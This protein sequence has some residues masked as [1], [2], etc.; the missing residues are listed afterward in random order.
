M[1]QAIWLAALAV[2]N[3]WA[4]GNLGSLGVPTN[5]EK[6]MLGG[7]A[8]GT[9]A[10]ALIGRGNPKAMEAGLTLPPPHYLRHP[11]QYF[12][13]SPVTTPIPMQPW[14]AD[15]VGERTIAANDART[16]IRP[17]IPLGQRVLCD[18]P[19]THQEILRAMPR[20]N[21]GVPFVYEEFRD[22][23]E[24]ATE[25]L[26]DKID[27]PRFYPLIGPAQMHHCHW[28]CTVY[29]TETV[30]V[31]YPFPMKTKR[32]RME[33]VYIDKDHLHLC[34]G[35][36]QPAAP[37][38]TVDSS[39][40]SEVTYADDALHPNRKIPGLTGRVWL[41]TEK[42]EP[43]DADGTLTVEMFDQN[44]EI[45]GKPQLLSVWTF[46]AAVL[47]Q[48][49]SKDNI[50]VGY[51]LF[52]PCDPASARVQRVKLS[53]TY[54]PAA[55]HAATME[56]AVLKLR[57]VE[58][59]TPAGQWEESNEPPLNSP[60]KKMSMSE[61]MEV[62]LEKFGFVV[63]RYSSDPMVRMEQLLVD[64]EDLR[65]M[66]DEWR[67]FWMVDQPSHLTPY[68]IHGGVGPASSSITDE[69]DPRHVP[70]PIQSQQF[71]IQPK[72][73]SSVCQTLEIRVAAPDVL[74]IDTCKLVSKTGKEMPQVVQQIRGEHL[75]RP[76]GT[77][78]LGTLGCVKVDGMTLAQVKKVVE[79]H[80][81]TYFVE[82]SVAVDVKAY[83]SSKYYVILD[84]K[85]H[86]QQVMAFPCTGSETVVLA[87]AQVT[88]PKGSLRMWVARPTKCEPEIIPVDW[89]AITEQGKTQT[90]YLLQAGDR[91]HIVAEPTP[92]R[93]TAAM[94]SQVQMS[95]LIAEVD[96]AVFAKLPISAAGNE[97]VRFEVLSC[98]K[99]L[100][101][102]LEELREQ[103][104]VKFIARPN[105]ITLSG[106]E[107]NVFTGSETPML[108]SGAVDWKL[109]Y[110]R[111]GTAVN[112]LP[113]VL[114]DGRIQLKV[115]GEIC[116]ANAK[117][118]KTVDVTGMMADGQ[119]IVITGEALR[120]DGRHGLIVV[121]PHLV[122]SQIPH[123]VCDAPMP[124]AAKQSMTLA[125]VVRLSKRGIADDIIIRQMEITGTVFHLSV[126]DIL[127]LNEQKV[128]DDVIRAMQ[129][130]AK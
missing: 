47:K 96:A 118:K 23:I 30:E 111:V 108:V 4:A 65:Q 21:R 122:Q 19:P 43:V 71:N 33:V 50:G 114:A 17:P 85:T 5:T 91:L 116:E 68:R 66:H 104:K 78:S 53:V 95:V 6:G 18:E 31:S 84:C 58:G 119:T 98:D 74:T 16:P 120:K 81:A 26:T 61:L 22:D 117:S 28:K 109:F 128:S 79:H 121:T 86:G 69:P 37:R 77:I 27:S 76:D 13:P 100:A 55:G 113:I 14:V 82:P 115:G 45:K 9:G 42:F 57:H 89:K 106:R 20:A 48:L 15:P 36:P 88:L 3:M 41:F 72:P 62:L 25:K 80:L 7:A 101:N 39:F 73:T 127:H 59:L 90:N 112:L 130:S 125:D 38:F 110:E 40:Q 35:E 67:K 97:H 32:R 92:Q 12:P 99:Q 83:N 124:V 49:A 126:D 8:I 56:T 75:V 107:A 87:T 105:V 46:D 24:I 34:T 123:G 11:P 102:Q 1:V 51:S 10:G 2:A 63:N 60:P 52:L 29:F 129:V 94:K 93:A 44:P 70:F 54:A 103:G 64:S